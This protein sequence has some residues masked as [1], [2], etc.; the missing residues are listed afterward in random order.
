MISYS[1]HSLLSE[2]THH[3]RGLNPV[4]MFV[5]SPVMVLTDSSCQLV[6]DFHEDIPGPRKFKGAFE[7]FEASLSWN[8][9]CF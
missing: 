9:F 3:H 2:Q 5:D 8:W 4:C 1:N 7:R 6:P